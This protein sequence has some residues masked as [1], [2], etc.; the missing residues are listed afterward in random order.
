M[1]NNTTTPP[2][3]IFYG[4]NK[5]LAFEYEGW[6]SA[7]E[8][9]EAAAAFARSKG[10]SLPWVLW[11]TSCSLSRQYCCTRKEVCGTLAV[12]IVAGCALVVYAT[13]GRAV[14][15]GLLTSL[16]LPQ[17]QDSSQLQRGPLL[18]L[19]GPKEAGGAGAGDKAKGCACVASTGTCCALR[20]NPLSSMNGI[21]HKSTDFH[22]VSKGLKEKPLAAECA[23]NQHHG[24]KNPMLNPSVQSNLDCPSTFHRFVHLVYQVLTWLPCV[25]GAASRKREPKFIFKESISAD[26]QI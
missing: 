10:E 24:K 3:I 12:L 6:R 14:V 21:G 26:R 1:E 13:A 22:L 19:I 8:I 11:S 20:R 7:D 9:L 15:R 18:P 4:A 16:G 5:T 25:R 2:A 23:R 17:E